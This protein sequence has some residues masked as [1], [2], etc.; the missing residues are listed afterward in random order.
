MKKVWS[1]SSI[2]LVLFSLGFTQNGTELHSGP[3]EVRVD[4]NT[5]PDCFCLEC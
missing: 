4:P 2:I 3:N 1:L 5:S